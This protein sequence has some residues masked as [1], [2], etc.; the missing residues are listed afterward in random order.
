M[1][2]KRALLTRLSIT[3]M[4]VTLAPVAAL[5]GD[6]SYSSVIRHIKSNYHAKQQGFFGAMM[7]ARFAVKVI[8]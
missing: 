2:N 5:A 6:E 3:V 4:L 7:L 8:K 1:T